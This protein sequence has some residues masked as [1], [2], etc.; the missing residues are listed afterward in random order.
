[1]HVHPPRRAVCLNTTKCATCVDGYVLN[2]VVDGSASA[3]DTCTLRAPAPVVS[4]PADVT[5]PVALTLAVPPVPLKKPNA[6]L[7]MHQHV[8]TKDTLRRTLE[9]AT[10]TLFAPTNQFEIVS[11]EVADA[12]MGDHMREFRVVLRKSAE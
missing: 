3:G 5:T 7:V 4:I 1:M 6:P 10:P 12:K 11:I 9:A 8:W 2:D